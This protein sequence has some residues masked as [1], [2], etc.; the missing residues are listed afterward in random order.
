MRILGCCPL[1]LYVLA[2]KPE[3]CRSNVITLKHHLIQ[4]KFCDR[5]PD[6]VN[7]CIPEHSLS[8]TYFSSLISS[9][10]P[11]QSAI[12]VADFSV[13][14]NPPR[15]FPPRTLIPPHISAGVLSVLYHPFQ[16]LPL[17]VTHLVLTDNCV[18]PHWL[19]QQRKSKERGWPNNPSQRTQ[20]AVLSRTQAKAVCISAVTLLH[21]HP[22]KLSVKFVPGANPM[23]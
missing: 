18:L 9:E 23:M 20:R 3:A 16:T 2:I 17:H 7:T 12:P 6:P 19:Q 14:P 10:S 4:L 5:L 15:A 21:P 11:P 8:S 22:P 13:F 1:A